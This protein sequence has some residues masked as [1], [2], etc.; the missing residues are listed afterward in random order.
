[1]T[2]NDIIRH[3]QQ[4]EAERDHARELAQYMVRHIEDPAYEHYYRTEIEKWPSGNPGANPIA[5]FIQAHIK[6]IPLYRANG[7][8]VYRTYSS[9]CSRGGTAPLTQREFNRQ[10]ALVKGVRKGRTKCGVEWIGC[11]LCP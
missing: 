11:L 1:M 7:R 6:I 9:F 2:T 4:L 3:I 5:A 8:A 10:L